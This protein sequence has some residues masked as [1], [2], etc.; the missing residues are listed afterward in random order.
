MRC[1]YPTVKVLFYLS[2]LTLS[3]PSKVRHHRIFG[4]ISVKWDEL[5]S[6]LNAKFTGL[7]QPCLLGWNHWQNYVFDFAYVKC[8]TWKIM[9]VSHELASLVTPT[10][11]NTPLWFICWQLCEFFLFYTVKPVYNGHVLSGHPLLSGQC[12]KSWFFAYTN[13]VFVTCISG[14]LY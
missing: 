4:G 12:S 11:M 5:V 1:I 6:P 2:G 13:T 9:S 7:T 3:Q 8:C 10:N 14:H